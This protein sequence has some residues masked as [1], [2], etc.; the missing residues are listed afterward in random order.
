MLRDGQRRCA[1]R[2][3]RV[4]A[5]APSAFRESGSAAAATDAAEATIAPAAT[6]VGRNRNIRNVNIQ[7]SIFIVV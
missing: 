4:T 3:P 7:P 1:V 2:G 5:T 6:Y